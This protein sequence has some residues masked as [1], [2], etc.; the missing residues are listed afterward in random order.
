MNAL[1]ERGGIERPETEARRPL[2]P[3]SLLAMLIFI[4]SELMFFAAF[5]S[6]HMITKSAATVW[7]PPGQPRLPVEQTAL[8]TLVLL[9]SG[10]ALVLVQ[11]HHARGSARALA[12]FN[13]SLY[14]GAFFVVFQG[15][16]WLGL[17]R[18]G[19]TLTSSSQGSFFYLIIGM[20]GLHA[21]AALLTLAWAR[22]KLR[23]G[24]LQGE[25]LIGVAAFWYFVVAIWPVLYTQVY[26]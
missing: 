23:R 9:A 12:W 15:Y 16:E 6:A 1:A 8:N 25:T 11:R 3:S 10:L 24:T 26:L 19:L 20:H 17:L 2:V 18:E 7:P 13:A 22:R 5:V 14:L 21:V 4:G